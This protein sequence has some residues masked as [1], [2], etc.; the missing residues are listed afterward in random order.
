MKTENKLK[1]FHQQFPVGSQLTVEGVN[2]AV[3]ISFDYLELMK[4]PQFKT[5][6]YE[7]DATRFNN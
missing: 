7:M 1:T 2:L 4:L 6:S 5:V 3:D